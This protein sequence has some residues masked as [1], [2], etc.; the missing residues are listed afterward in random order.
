MHIDTN[1]LPEHLKRELTSLMEFCS[2]QLFPVDV[3]AVV[4]EVIGDPALQQN[5]GSIG[6][7]YPTS[8][9][10]DAPFV[11]FVMEIDISGMPDDIFATVAHEMVH[12]KQYV[13]REMSDGPKSNIV[14]WQGCSIDIHSMPYIDYPWEKE[15]YAEQELLLESW[16]LER[17]MI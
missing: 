1:Q 7:V 11:D 8:D 13:T 16:K 4:I 17:K 9:L 2:R 12:V 3:S 5:E 15:A 10:D 6:T 14:I